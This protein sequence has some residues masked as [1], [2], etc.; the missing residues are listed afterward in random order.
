MRRAILLL[1][2]TMA[3]LASVPAAT[4]DVRVGFTSG[5]GIVLQPAGTN[6]WRIVVEHFADGSRNG[7]RV[8]QVGI[9]DPRISGSDC[10]TNAFLNDVVCNG[11]PTLVQ[12]S[13]SDD[14]RNELVVGGSNVGCEPGPP[15]LV[16]MN[17]GGG[18]DVVRPSFACGGQQLVSGHNRLSPRFSTI[19]G[20]AGD[21]SLTGGRLDDDLRGDSGNDSIAGGIDADTL[22]G[23]DGNDALRGQ[24]G[25]DTLEGGAGAD[26]LDGGGQSDTV[27]YDVLN[28]LVI[29]LDGAA[30]DGRSGEG[31]NVVD[32]ETVI[33]G[34]GN[35]RVTGSSAAET[36]GGGAGDDTLIPGTGTDTARGEAGNDLIDVRESNEGIQDSVTCGTGIDEVIA[37]L[38]DSVATRVILGQSR[39]AAC[40][41]VERFAVDD[42]PPGRVRARSVRIARDGRLTLPVSCPRRARVTCRGTLRLV[43]NRRPGRTLASARYAVPRRTRARVR[44]RL[45]P[46]QARRARSRRSLTAITRE[47][48]VSKKGPR[49]AVTTM[50]V[51]RRAG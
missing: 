20:G 35:D 24:G 12:A 50:A 4:A 29:T 51:S 3:A 25:S 15:V 22:S 47:R 38:S 19:S 40:E 36:L 7:T 26:L 21:D 46:A 49:S 45:A 33:A 14:A 32:V 44:L 31:D 5:A 18:D 9:G 30:N 28:S 13:Q 17:M 8:R 37:D 43:D 16:F 48:G 6:G 39:D 10:T 41:R 42:G 11:I 23:G 34:A 2:L 27:R 1:A